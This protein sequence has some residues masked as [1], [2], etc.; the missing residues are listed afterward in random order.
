MEVSYDKATSMKNWELSF[1][2]MDEL[3][4]KRQRELALATAPTKRVEPA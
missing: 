3:Q 1:E 4:A 2:F